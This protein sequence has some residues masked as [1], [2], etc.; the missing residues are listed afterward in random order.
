[1]HV[2]NCILLNNGKNEIEEYNSGIAESE[3]LVIAPQI[4][5]NSDYPNWDKAFERILYD[6]NTAPLGTNQY[7]A[8]HIIIFTAHKTLGLPKF[9][10]RI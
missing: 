10:E 5:C 6:F 4:T 9:T 1:M 2:L 3:K 7:I 8:N